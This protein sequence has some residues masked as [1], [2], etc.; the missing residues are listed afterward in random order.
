MPRTTPR[1]VAHEPETNCVL[2]LVYSGPKRFVL[3]LRDDQF[4][5]VRKVSPPSEEMWSG[6][7]GTEGYSV[8]WS[9]EKLSVQPHSGKRGANQ[10]L[11]IE[12]HAAFEAVTG[13][14]VLD[15]DDVVHAFG[16][17]GAFSAVEAGPGFVWHAGSAGTR[18][19]AL[20]DPKW[21]TLAKPLPHLHTVA[22]EPNQKVFAAGSRAGTVQLVREKKVSEAK[23]SDCWC[24]TSYAG[25]FYAWSNHQV[26]RIDL[27][28]KVTQL[29]V[30]GETHRDTCL[31]GT[32]VGLFFAESDTLH[33]FH[34]NRWT[35]LP[36]TNAP[37][38]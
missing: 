13:L 18:R 4:E 14:H 36:L 37:L 19:R 25:A 38:S 33:R 27:D 7:D 26:Q 23:L 22:F 6:H 21:K 30:T 29:E 28:G 16:S 10:K 35:A 34:D 5:F 31:F 32:P 3:R 17:G 24:L 1:S 8:F 12:R 15:K 9:I 2:V 20:S 11:G